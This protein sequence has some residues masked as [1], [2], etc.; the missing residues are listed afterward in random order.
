MVR[1]KLGVSEHA[2]PHRAGLFPGFFSYSDLL[3]GTRAARM[4]LF[5]S[6]GLQPTCTVNSGGGHRSR[7]M[8]WVVALVAAAALFGGVA[9]TTS[10]QAITPQLT[11][12]PGT[13]DEVVE[14]CRQAVIAAAQGHASQQGAELIRVDATSAGEMRRVGRLQAAP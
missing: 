1:A 12:R 6:G 5:R 9:I 2:S 11:H 3:P 10:Q 4:N 7:V 14:S 13:P 8:T